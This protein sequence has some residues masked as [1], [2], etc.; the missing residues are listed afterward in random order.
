MIFFSALRVL[1]F[2]LFLPDA[3]SLQVT[4]FDCMAKNANYSVFS[5]EDVTACPKAR[6]ME[7]RVIQT[8]QIL[9]TKQYLPTLVRQLSL[10]HI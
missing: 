1:L 6:E 8:V 4:G 3:W 9:Q 5:L 2:I 7:H 10:I